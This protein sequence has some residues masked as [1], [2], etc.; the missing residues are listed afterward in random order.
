MRL[1]EEGMQRGGGPH[2]YLL[3]SANNNIPS[4]RLCDYLRR[5]P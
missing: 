4:F 1:Q 3:R 5:Y 2:I